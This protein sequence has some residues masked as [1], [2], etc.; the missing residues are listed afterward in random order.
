MN[1][2][3][4]I[5]YVIPL[6]L[7]RDFEE[8]SSP[9]FGQYFATFFVSCLSSRDEPTLI[10]SLSGKNITTISCGSSHSAAISV[11][12][13]LYTWGQGNY[14]RLGHGTDTCWVSQEKCYPLDY[15]Q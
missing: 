13:E 6:L 10:T 1:C 8:L 7:Y 3:L 14:G 15:E 12:G 5:K 2:S 9:Y 11:D 4:P